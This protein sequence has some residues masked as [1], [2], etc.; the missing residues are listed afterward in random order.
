MNIK[1]LIISLIILFINFILF[2][3]SSTDY[4]NRILNYN[5]G[6]IDNNYD[7]LSSGTILLRDDPANYSIYEKLEAEIR[8]IGKRINNDKDMISYYTYMEAVLSELSTM[9]QRIRELLVQKDNQLLSG[10]D[11]EI[12]NNEIRQYY[13][14]MEYDISQAEFN[15]V[16]IFSDLFKNADLKNYFDNKKYY[17]FQ[18]VDNLLNFVIKQRSTTGSYAARLEYQ[19]NGEEIKKQN[20]IN[21]KKQQDTDYSSEISA[22]KRNSLLLMINV[23]MLK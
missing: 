12:I 6:R 19:N 3:N 11:K 8:E 14:Q 22:L 15:Q 16:K 21:F 9:L 17:D 5:E 7:R 18:N 2:S 1:K 20:T 23:M 13:R 4:L 10:D